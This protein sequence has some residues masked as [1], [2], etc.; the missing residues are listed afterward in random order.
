MRLYIVKLI[1]VIKSCISN[2]V[3]LTCILKKKP[4]LVELVNLLTDIEYEWDKIGIAL[5]V[6][7]RVL[8]GLN[9]SHDDNTAKLITV[10][11]SWMDTFPSSSTWDV[12]LAAVEG[13]I[14]KHPSTALKIRK[15]LAKPEVHSKYK[16][17]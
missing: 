12:V 3:D 7:D 10:L 11:R 5:E 17:K 1:F 15:F 13:P 4:K 16:V 9:R 8:G 14:V 6:E 2:V